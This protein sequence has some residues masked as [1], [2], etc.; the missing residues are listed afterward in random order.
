M[1]EALKKIVTT[2]RKLDV[3]LKTLEVRFAG[4]WNGKVGLLLSEPFTLPED[5]KIEQ[6]APVATPDG[7][8]I[9]VRTPTGEEYFEGPF[10]KKITI[11]HCD[12]FGPLR[13][14]KGQVEYCKLCGG[15]PT[16]YL[17]YMRAKLDENANSSV[18]VLAASSE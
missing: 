3:K 1:R 13:K 15:L 16:K 6:K 4:M 10:G 2:F 11:E 14:L 12:I 17:K 5:E 7:A 8:N 18:P 9:L